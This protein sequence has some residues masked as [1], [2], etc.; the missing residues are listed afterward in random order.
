MKRFTSIASLAMCLLVAI[1]LLA[2]CSSGES[3][4]S[5]ASDSPSQAAYPETWDEVFGDKTKEEEL[6]EQR[7]FAFESEIKHNPFGEEPF[8]DIDPDD[9]PVISVPD[10]GEVQYAQAQCL[11]E[12]GFPEEAN[13]AGAWWPTETYSDDEVVDFERASIICALEYPVFFIKIPRQALDELYDYQVDTV[14]PCLEDLGYEV[15]PPIAKQLWMD[16]QM[17]DQDTWDPFALIKESPVAEDN[18]EMDKIYTQC[19]EY[20][21]GFWPSY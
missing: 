7:Q 16:A 17:A 6:E 3:P 11:T 14:V 10:V 4:S 18:D 19:P 8:E 13:A 1:G 12:A 5:K 9:Y 20:P 2:S 15:D 21:E